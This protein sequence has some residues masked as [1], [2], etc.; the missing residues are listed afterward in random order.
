MKL[1]ALFTV[2]GVV[3]MIWLADPVFAYSS[4]PRQCTAVEAVICI[5]K[6]DRKL[7][8]V[9]RGQIVL[10]IDA[11]FGDA[12]G[13]AFRTAEGMFTVYRKVAM[14]YSRQYNNA[15]MPYSMYFHGG[16]AVHYSYSFAREGY[17]GSSHGCV[18]VRD[19]AKLRW[20]YNRV[21]QGTP[22]Y[23]YS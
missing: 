12:R 18:N 1:A 16:Q 11:R 4:L 20:L 17:N 9:R 3:I 13:P 5:S 23:I 10:S 6:A 8:F 2:V 7:R 21:P 22:V 15:P 19:M 14:D